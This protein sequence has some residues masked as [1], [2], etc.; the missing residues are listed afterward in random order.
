MEHKFELDDIIN[1]LSMF[2]DIH[3]NPNVSNLEFTFSITPDYAI[4]YISDFILNIITS[5]LYDY[6]II[7]FDLCIK[8]FINTVENISIIVRCIYITLL[9]AIKLIK[10]NIIQKEID[11]K[12]FNIDTF[13]NIRTLYYNK[14]NLINKYMS[15]LTKHIIIKGNNM[16]KIVRDYA[17]YMGF[18]K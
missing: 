16:L 3:I 13:I 17:F 15:F 5:D 10:S 11:D 9:K 6:N 1:V 4:K 12:T 8:K 18:F 2:G 7:L 14:T